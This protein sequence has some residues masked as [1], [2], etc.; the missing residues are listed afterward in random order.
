MT[1]RQGGFVPLTFYPVEAG[2][3]WDPKFEYFHTAQGERIL[4]DCWCT[5][6]YPEPRFPGVA[7]GSCGVAAVWLQ[8]LRRAHLTAFK[9]GQ[10]SALLG[11]QWILGSYTGMLV[12]AEGRQLNGK[13]KRVS[14]FSSILSAL[15]LL[16]L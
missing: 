16:M 15:P 14:K 3:R 7:Q 10:E 1:W 2:S 6:P 5:S 4:V 12:W 9:E 8:P 13:R 11:V